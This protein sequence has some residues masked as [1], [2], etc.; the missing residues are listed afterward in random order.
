VL[1]VIDRLRD[2][3][4]TAREAA[5][6]ILTR[7]A[8]EQRDL[9][10]DE[11]AEHRLHV[12]AEREAADELE[13]A[14][15]AQIAE[16]RAAGARNGGRQVLTR[17]AAETARA[18]RSAI[19]A[20]NPAPIEVY[21]TDLADEWPAD[22][23]EPL[24]RAGRVRVHTR[25]TLK[26]TA[27]Q[28]LGTSSLMAA[29]ATGL[30]WRDLD[31]D[32]GKASIRQTVI[33]I[34]HAVM[35][36]TPKT[37]KGRRTVT[38]DSGTVAALREHRKRQAAERLLMGAGWTDLDLVF[39]HPDRGPWC[40]LSGSLVASWRQWRGSGC[41]V[42]GCMICGMAGQRWRCRPVFIRRWCRSG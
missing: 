27:T 3:R 37:A 7:A 12:I 11:I 32:N 10:P 19:F 28:A 5:D 39:C 20:K 36:G 42:S 6:Q 31:L 22:V 24:G 16:L 30:R 33:A 25:D 4:T 14:R 38:L 2:Q 26:S 41:R 29:G 34:R 40:I 13:R 23:P 35:I 8:E 21:A 1:S 18:F 17:E 15:D 9:S